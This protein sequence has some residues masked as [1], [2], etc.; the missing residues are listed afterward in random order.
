MVGGARFCLLC[1]GDLPGDEAGLAVC[2]ACRA[3]LIPLHPPGRTDDEGA[4]D[5]FCSRCGEELI[6]RRGLLCRSCLEDPF[7]ADSGFSLYPYRDAPRELL[8]LYKKSG[9]KTL[10][11]FFAADLHRQYFSLRE[12]LPLVPVPPSPRNFKERGWDPLN[13]LCRRLARDYGLTVLPLLRRLPSASQKTLDRQR[14]LENLRG[15]FVLRRGIRT[16]PPRVCLI[17]D[18]WTT[19]STLRECIR[20]LREA[21]VGEVHALTL[22]RD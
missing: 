18:V 9:L 15:K 10:G 17:D 14:R 3:A 2:P 5:F 1:G 6:S 7:P 19:G 11:D 22:V 4:A 13:F 12:K 20:V 21:G 16:I 8:Y